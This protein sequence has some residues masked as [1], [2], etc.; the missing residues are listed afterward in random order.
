MITMPIK[1]QTEEG[2][3]EIYYTIRE[4]CEKT[5]LSRAG[6]ALRI[7]NKNAAFKEAGQPPIRKK[8]K[9]NYVYISAFD[10]ARI[11]SFDEA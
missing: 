10:V 8:K 4:V 11:D 3:E 5:G 6:L 9:G 1:L 7:D 2:T